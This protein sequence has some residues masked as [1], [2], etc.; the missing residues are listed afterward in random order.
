MLMVFLSQRWI[1]VDW[2]ILGHIG[3][4]W[5]GKDPS[6]GLVGYKSP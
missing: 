2:D 1:D 6:L 3:T 5:D 4:Y